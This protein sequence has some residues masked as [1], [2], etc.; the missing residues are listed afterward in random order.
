MHLLVGCT[1]RKVGILGN[2]NGRKGKG[3]F[4]GAGHGKLVPQPVPRWVKAGGKNSLPPG[5]ATTIEK[6]GLGGF[7]G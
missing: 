4:G 2:E 5:A 3:R 1:S 7:G 6:G